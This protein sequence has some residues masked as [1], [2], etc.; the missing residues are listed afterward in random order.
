MKTGNKPHQ[1]VVK[2][3]VTK[4]IKMVK[5][6]IGGYQTKRISN[7]KI[8]DKIASQEHHEHTK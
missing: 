5:G 8:V 6:K 1:S 3:K 2:S 7:N 4:R